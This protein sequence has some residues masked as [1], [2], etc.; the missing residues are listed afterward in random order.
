MKME[1]LME[2][3]KDNIEEYEKTL[4][5][6]QLVVFTEAC[7]SII[8]REDDIK[9]QYKSVKKY[10]LVPGILGGI[11]LVSGLAI[12]GMDFKIVPNIYIIKKIFLYTMLLNAISYKL[13]SLKIND[14]ESL[15]YE[16]NYDKE[17]IFE[18][19]NKSEYDENKMHKI[20]EKR[21]V[22]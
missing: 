9:K 11:G 22:K 14:I 2:V 8:E 4:N 6:E 17:I 3:E 18:D 19:V 5:P 16:T 12:L 13:Y 1:K 20:L 15:A 10:R 7:Q 21:L